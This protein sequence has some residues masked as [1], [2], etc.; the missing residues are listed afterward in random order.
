[1]NAGLSDRAAPDALTAVVIYRVTDG[2]I[3]Q[4]MLLR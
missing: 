4:V 3:S 2:K 1:V